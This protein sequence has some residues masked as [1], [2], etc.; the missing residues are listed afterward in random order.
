LLR[1][2]TRFHDKKTLD[3]KYVTGLSDYRTIGVAK[4]K[5]KLTHNENGQ[6]MLCNANKYVAQLLRNQRQRKRKSAATVLVVCTG[7]WIFV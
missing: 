7:H 6:K 1:K 3:Y 5:G 2:S 4:S